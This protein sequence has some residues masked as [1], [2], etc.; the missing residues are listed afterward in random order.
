MD[1]FLKYP[2]EVQNETL[3]KL[4][5]KAKETEVGKRYNFE[6]IKNYQDFK[7]QVPIRTYEVIEQEIDRARNGENNIFWPSHIKWFAKSSGT[8][9]LKVNLFR[10]VQKPL[11]IVILKQEKIY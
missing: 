2:I 9:M 8:T 1:L 11:K 6:N 7:K 10:L 4:V 5:D 3:L